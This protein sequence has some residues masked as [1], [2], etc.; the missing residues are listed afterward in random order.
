MKKNYYKVHITEYLHLILPINTSNINQCLL[1]KLG[2][3]CDSIY[4]STDD[5]WDISDVEV[6]N[7]DCKSFSYLPYNSNLS[8]TVYPSIKQTKVPYLV[9]GEYYGLV[10][11][12]TS[13]KELN[14]QNNEKPTEKI[15]VD[16]L[17]LNFGDTTSIKFEQSS[18]KVFRLQNVPEFET[19][20]VYLKSNNNFT[21]HKIL[22]KFSS[23]PTLSSF[24]YISNSANQNAAQLVVS[25]TKAGTYYISIE[26]SASFT[27]LS[28]DIQLTVKLAKFEILNVFPTS[29]LK[30]YST[31]LKITGT[32]FGKNLQ[33]YL[34]TSSLAQRIYS[35]RVDFI[36]SELVYAR[37]LITDEINSGLT[38][39][40]DDSKQSVNY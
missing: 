28:Y 40:L 22:A 5:K 2:I 12:R 15:R 26:S 7:P 29:L 36:S 39:V 1:T 20:L 19:I 33:V 8:S 3:K 9:E 38:L 35:T 30:N 11:V 13:L 4:L 23:P 32:K 27:T 37:F 34:V 31:T 17:V 25:S 18:Y 16:A 21:F 24:D 14:L 6:V 10:K